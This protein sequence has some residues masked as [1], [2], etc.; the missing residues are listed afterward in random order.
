MLFLLSARCF[1]LCRCCRMTLLELQKYSSVCCFNCCPVCSLMQRCW[2]YGPSCLFVCC[3]LRCKTS[4]PSG[5]INKV[6]LEIEL[7]ERLIP[8]KHILANDPQQP[9]REQM[10]RGVTAVP[11]TDVCILP[12][13][14]VA[15]KEG[16][17]QPS[18]VIITGA[19]AV[20]CFF[21]I[22]CVPILICVPG[23]WHNSLLCHP[24][25]STLQHVIKTDYAKDRARTRSEKSNATKA[26]TL[27]CI[28]FLDWSWKFCFCFLFFFYRKDHQKC[29]VLW[30][31]RY[32]L[33]FD[34]PKR[35]TLSGLLITQMY[36]Q[37]CLRFT[38][39]PVYV[40]NLLTGWEN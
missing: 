40:L 37:G 28:T 27:N 39:C 29:I 5:V 35:K 34:W 26:C 21:I 38:S 23:S 33:S 2:A 3:P 1:W 14:R 15:A 9:L 32:C 16:F 6:T 22:V 19:V 31:N 12:D 17:S 36:S 4:C 24:A 20:W 13:M 8:E 25:Y 18:C 10:S 30:T 11:A 7:V